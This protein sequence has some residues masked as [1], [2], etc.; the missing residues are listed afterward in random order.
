MSDPRH[1][2]GRFV[3]DS[4]P[5]P[6]L[7]ARHIEQIASLP[8]RMRMA[9]RGLSEA[10]LNTPY[11]DGGW[12]VR[13]LVHHVPDSHLNAYTRCKLA[14]TEDAPTIKPYDQTAWA[15]LK[16]SELTP[17][18]VSLTL[19]ECIHTRWVTL[20]RSLEPQHFQRRFNHPEM[21][22]MTVDDLVAQYDWHGNHHLAHITSLRE[23]M[24][25]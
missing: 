23:K 21:G 13:T 14:L 5:T 8:P 15:L 11:R 3:P 10:Q 4:S 19:L 18:E 7:R 24:K 1:P 9:V 20:L 17:I 2:V 25:W 6:E 22:A 16:D 12:K